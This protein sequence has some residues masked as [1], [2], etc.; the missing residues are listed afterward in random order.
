MHVK[1]LLVQKPRSLV[2]FGK[3]TQEPAQRVGP[4][5]IATA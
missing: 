5:D 3:A 4:N 1:G 2:D